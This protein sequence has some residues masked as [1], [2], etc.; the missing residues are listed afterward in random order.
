MRKFYLAAG[1][2]A[3]CLASCK[4]PTQFETYCATSARQTCAFQ[5]NCCTDTERLAS[6]SPFFLTAYQDESECVESINEICL[7]FG[8][9]EMRSEE[10]GRVTVTTDE[11]CI[12]ALDAVVDTCNNAESGKFN[13]CLKSEPAVDDGGACASSAECKSGLCVLKDPAA[14][15]AETSSRIGSC[16]SRG[17]EG[18]A[19]TDDQPCIDGLA[20]SDEVCKKPLNVDAVCTFGGVPCAQGLICSDDG[21]D[22]KCKVAPA[23]GSAC[24]DFQCN[25]LAYC[26]AATDQ[27][28]ARGALGAV[29]DGFDTCAL[30]LF[31][32]DG[33]CSDGEVAPTAGVCDGI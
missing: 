22:E 31:C 10:L 32:D 26:D 14:F 15:D 13:D 19:C 23:A 4:G 3:A 16:L 25:D 18:A 2:A 1:I 12:T 29:C 8:D 9:N 5:Y 17:A 20:C 24:S 11:A 30:D 7:L 6:T 33:K 28:V 21:A 27:C